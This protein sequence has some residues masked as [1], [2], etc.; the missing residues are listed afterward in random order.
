MAG[1]CLYT[2]ASDLHLKTGCYPDSRFF[3]VIKLRFR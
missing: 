2:S 3:I 1:G